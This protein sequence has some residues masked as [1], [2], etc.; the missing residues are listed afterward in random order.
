MQMKESK[1][2]TPRSIPKL[3]FPGNWPDRANALHA[4]L[5]SSLIQRHARIVASLFLSSSDFPV[6]NEV[7]S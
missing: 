4:L 7:D 3:M 2:I 1:H 5:L 6:T